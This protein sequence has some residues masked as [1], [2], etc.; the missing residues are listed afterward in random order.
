MGL[1]SKQAPNTVCVWWWVSLS[2]MIGK[3][4][5]CASSPIQARRSAGRD[6]TPLRPTT[7][8]VTPLSSPDTV[9]RV[10]EPNGGGRSLWREFV[11]LFALRASRVPVLRFGSARRP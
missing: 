1:M 5:G 8:V 9:C 6:H 10:R 4:H 3:P 2:G 7:A 11:R